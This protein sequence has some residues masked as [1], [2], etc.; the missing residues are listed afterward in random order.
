MRTSSFLPVDLSLHHWYRLTFRVDVGFVFC[1]L[2]FE[3]EK[4]KDRFVWVEDRCEYTSSWYGERDRDRGRQREE[5]ERKFICLH[6]L[7]G[8]NILSCFLL[9]VLYLGTR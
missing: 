6:E 3:R 7:S 1:H 8:A 2:D 4:I 5:R 9:H